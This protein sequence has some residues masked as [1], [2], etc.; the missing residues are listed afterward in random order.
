MNPAAKIESVRIRGFRSLS[1]VEFPDLPNVA[2]LIGANG[3]GK[4]NF[5]SFLEMVQQMLRY[6]RLGDFVARQGG[7]DDQLFGGSD[8]TAQMDAEF[9]VKTAQGKYDYRFTLI[10]TFIAPTDGL[11]F[12]VL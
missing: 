12:S 9:K 8:R 4:S 3:S 2:V 5:L 10:C 7:A 6:R 1:D 11:Y